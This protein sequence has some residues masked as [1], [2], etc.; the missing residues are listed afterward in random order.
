MP[1]STHGG[2]AT[3]HRIGQTITPIAHSLPV[4]SNVPTSSSVPN[5]S[6]QNRPSSNT[7]QTGTGAAQGNTP[8]N[9][10]S[11]ARP[12]QRNTQQTG[13]GATQGNTLQI[14]IGTPQ[15]NPQSGAPTLQAHSNWKHKTLKWP[16]LSLIIFFQCGFISALLYL[17]QRSQKNTGFVDVPAVPTLQ[18][19][20]NDPAGLL[21]VPLWWQTFPTVVFAVYASLWTSTINDFTERQP[22]VDLSRVGGD[23]ARRTVV[24]EYQSPWVLPAIGKMIRNRHSTLTAGN[25]LLF[26][27]TIFVVPFSA[28]IFQ[29]ASV[30]TQVDVDVV[31]ITGFDTNQLTS[32]TDFLSI[33]ANATSSLVSGAPYPAWTTANVSIPQLSLPRDTQSVAFNDTTLTYN[34]SVWAFSGDLDCVAIN[35]ESLNETVDGQLLPFSFVDRGC[36]VYALFVF[37]S[38]KSIFFQGFTN[39]SCSADTG[40]S[41]IGLLMTLSNS[42]AST[43]KSFLVSCIPK[44][45]LQYG[46]V[47]VLPSNNSVVFT[48]DLQDVKGFNFTTAWYDMDNKIFQDSVVQPETNVEASAFSQLIYS[49]AIFQGNHEIGDMPTGQEILDATQQAF[50]TFLAYLGSTILVY[51]LENKNTILRGMLLDTVQRLFVISAIAFALVAVLAVSL[52][53]TVIIGIYT[54]L[55]STYLNEEPIGLLGF[56]DIVHDSAGLQ[57]FRQK[58][59]LERRGHPEDSRYK[60]AKR[61]GFFK[62]SSTWHKGWTMDSR[63]KIVHQ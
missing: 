45:R 46:N 6:S 47:T 26:V 61:A 49:Y 13:T 40:F 42:E 27:T 3:T 38:L 10:Q 28:F 11:S 21:V 58:I 31:Q 52:I 4:Q 57:A 56:E 43:M 55:H 9:A 48:P 35:N 60:L 62:S 5:I 53:Y 34:T 44:Y 18:I 17:R 41:R 54:S 59:D 16:Y 39:S 36:E 14:G 37:S 50:R 22:F 12:P 29:S 23:T 2:P 15:G 30:L 1:N 33:F 19:D 7:R 25:L 8:G 20:G 63:G 51:S 24:A 32:T